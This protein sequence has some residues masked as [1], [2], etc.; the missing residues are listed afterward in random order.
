MA[1]IS[2]NRSV[3]VDEAELQ[4]RFARSG[5]PGGQHVNTSSTKVELRWDVEGSDALD[6]AQKALVR[7]RLGSRITDD[8]VLVL[9]SSEHRS[10]TRNREA[11]LARFT[12]LV[13][14]AL[15][16]RTPRRAT[17]PSA[18]ARQRRLDAKK[19]TAQT[20]ALRRP[21]AV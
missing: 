15:R 17:A 2:I 20:K 14:D 6:E 19:R 8:G 4:W 11:A 13:S 9:H 16:T 18:A 10:Q 3:A 1:R 21:P 5:G 12:A 7:Q